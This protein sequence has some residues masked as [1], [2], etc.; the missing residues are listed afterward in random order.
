MK[1]GLHGKL[2]A[3]EG[4][5]KKLAEILL[6]AS[7]IVTQ[8]PSCYLYMV[9]IDSKDENTIWITEAWDSKQSHDESLQNQEVK[10]LIGNAI[11]LLAE[12]PKGGDE[13]RIIGGI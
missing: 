12:M 8:M 11:P 4:N 10:A 6:K 7:E 2:V 3:S 13:L 1:Y 9:S 5:G